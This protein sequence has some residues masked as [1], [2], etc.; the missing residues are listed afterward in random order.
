MEDFEF[1]NTEFLIYKQH[2]LNRDWANY[3]LFQ[4]RM[5]NTGRGGTFLHFQMIL[6]NP[7]KFVFSDSHDYMRAM[8][9]SNSVDRYGH[10][11][12]YR[13]S[14]DVIWYIDTWPIKRDSSYTPF[15]SHVILRLMETGNIYKFKENGFDRMFNERKDYLKA[16]PGFPDFE[17]DKPLEVPL[18]LDHLIGLF[19]V[20]LLGCLLGV[21]IFVAE[22][23]GGHVRKMLGWGSASKFEQH[24]QFAK[25]MSEGRNVPT[26]DTYGRIKLH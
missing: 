3:K 9:I 14:D 16:N 10:D 1:S 2:I 13:G 25:K 5:F 7:G 23:L 22:L 19:I 12:F 26:L 11:G 18:G 8:I 6:D 24:K 17:I 15:F 20:Y 21:I 4:D